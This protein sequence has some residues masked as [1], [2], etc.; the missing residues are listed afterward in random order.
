VSGSKPSDV[1]ALLIQWQ[2]GDAAALERL[3]R[4]VYVELHRLA[5]GYLCGERSGHT[6]QPTALI[7][8][9]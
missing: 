5:S 3:L 1:T 7:H 9:A 2:Q 8:E 4:L 6:L